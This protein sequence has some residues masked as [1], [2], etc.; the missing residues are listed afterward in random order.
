MVSVW[1]QHTMIQAGP[2]IHRQP[3]SSILSFFPFTLSTRGRENHAQASLLFVGPT[4]QTSSSPHASNQ[5]GPD[6]FDAIRANLF[7]RAGLGY[8]SQAG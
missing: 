1:A 7:L 5:V 2:G 6:V 4:I 8:E 3:R